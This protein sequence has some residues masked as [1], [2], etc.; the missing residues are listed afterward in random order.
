VVSI[1]LIAATVIGVRQ[2]LDYRSL[3]RAVGVCVAGF[4]IV[5]GVLAAVGALLSR[6]VS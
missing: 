4:L 2:A 5:L 6:T 1:W 3:G